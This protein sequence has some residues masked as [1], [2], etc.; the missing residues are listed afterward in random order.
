MKIFDRRVEKELEEKGIQPTE[1]VK[2]LEHSR[3]VLHVVI[4]ILATVVLALGAGLLY[5]HNKNQPQVSSTVASSTKEEA[6]Q[7]AKPTESTVDM[8]ADHLLK[9][10]AKE[11]ADE[12]TAAFKNWYTSFKNDTPILEINEELLENP[13]GT[14]PYD[15]QEKLVTNMKDKFG[16]LLAD[17]YYNS[18][19]D[20]L[21]ANPLTIDPEKGLTWTFEGDFDNWLITWLFDTEKDKKNTKIVIRNDF[22]YEWTD[23]KKFIEKEQNKDKFGNVLNSI[24]WDNDISHE[25]ITILTANDKKNIENLAGVFAVMQYNEKLGFWQLTG[26]MG[27]GKQ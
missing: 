21:N 13:S 6:N 24:D 15:L 14:S 10:S 22:P 26:T 27:G 8:G 12:A 2:K 7:Q 1:A 25:V 5:F 16:T 17:S 23:W 9:L 11:R 18:L 20:A 19:R 4:G 3:Q